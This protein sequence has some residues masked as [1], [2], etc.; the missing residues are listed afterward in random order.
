ML[1]QLIGLLFSLFGIFAIF[2]FLQALFAND[3]PDREFYVRLIIGAL[4]VVAFGLGFVMRWLSIYVV[5]I[6]GSLRLRLDHVESLLGPK[7]E[8]YAGAG[9]ALLDLGSRPRKA[10]L[11]LNSIAKDDLDIAATPYLSAVACWLLFEQEAG[12]D[13]HLHRAAAFAEQYARRRPDRMEAIAY[14]AAITGEQA[15]LAARRSDE[16][17]ARLKEAAASDLFARAA[18][19]TPTSESDPYVPAMTAGALKAA[20]DEFEKRLREAR[21]GPR[22]GQGDDAPNKRVHPPLP[23]SCPARRLPSHPSLRS[24]CQYGARQEHR[25]GTRTARRAKTNQR[26]DRRRQRQSQ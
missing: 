3:M 9:R 10:L 24:V 5:R 7:P 21:E 8:G 25:A 17:A 26:Y 19:M 18:A 4:G 16:T 20:Q 15:V 1:V 14:F 11:L 2:S 22:Q 23:H 13:E 12:K 6:M